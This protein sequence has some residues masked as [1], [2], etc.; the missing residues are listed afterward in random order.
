MTDRGATMLTKDPAVFQRSNNPREL[1]G[2][3]LYLR[4]AKIR[5]QAV[6][7]ATQFAR[8]SLR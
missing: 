3:A 4:C 2:M 8:L 6:A 1:V 7:A 5:D